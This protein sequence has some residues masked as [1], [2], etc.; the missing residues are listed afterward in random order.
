MKSLK[1]KTYLDVVSL[2]IDLVYDKA[3]WRPLK[4]KKMALWRRLPNWTRLGCCCC[5]CCFGAL[6]FHFLFSFFF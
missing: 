4:R 6:N 1:V 3:L 5:C 2:T